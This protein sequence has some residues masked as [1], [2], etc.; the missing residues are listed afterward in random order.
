MENKIIL[1]EEKINELI[2]RFKQVKEENISLKQQLLEKNK[3]IEQY[4]ENQ[5][6]AINKLDNLIEVLKKEGV[7]EENS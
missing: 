5:K 2:N 6:K 4:E 7:F 1:L 3:I